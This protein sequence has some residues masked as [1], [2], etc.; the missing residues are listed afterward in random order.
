M[1]WEEN[2]LKMI[3]TLNRKVFTNDNIK[4]TFDEYSKVDCSNKT[5]TLELKY[6]N[7][8]ST[9]YGDCFLEKMKYDGVMEKAKL[10]NK[11][12]GYIAA[13]SDDTYYAWNLTKLTE[14]GYDFKWQKI[15]MKR[16]THFENNEQIE[17]LSCKL[18]LEKGTK[19]I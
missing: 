6:R 3:N 13:F 11:T 5:Y 12:A 2:E 9:L 18:P 4:K 14:E 1:N 7:M 15:F 19:I 10:L 17:K 16:T 8:P